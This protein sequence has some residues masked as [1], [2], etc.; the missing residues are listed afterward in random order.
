[1]L[2]V[3]RKRSKPVSAVRFLGAIGTDARPRAVGKIRIPQI[4]DLG[5]K[6][7]ERLGYAFGRRHLAELNTINLCLYN[8]I[9]RR[10]RLEQRLHECEANLHRIID[11]L[12]D[13]IA[14]SR[15]ADAILI[16]V[17]QGFER[18]GY[19]REEALGRSWAQLGVWTAPRQH[20]EFYRRLAADGT[21]LEMEVSLRRRD[22]LKYPAH[23]SGALIELHGETCATTVMRDVSALRRAETSH[24][25]MCEAPL[26][27]LGPGTVPLAHISHEIRTAMNSILGTGELLNETVLDAVQHDYLDIMRRNGEALLGV[28]DGLFDPTGEG[29]ESIED[30]ASVLDLKPVRAAQGPASDAAENASHN[31]HRADAADARATRILLVEDSA[32]NRILVRTYLERI[33]CEIDEAEN[34]EIGVRK[35]AAGSYDIVL[36]DLHMPV[37]D[38][39]DATRM[40]REWEER[41]AARRTW[42]IALTASSY[43]DEV[44]QMI[45]AGADLDVRKPINRA[46][47]IAAVKYLRGRRADESIAVRAAAD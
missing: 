37:M 4:G 9:A 11:T 41:H 5:A 36:M 15:F 19:R 20:E 47:L 16:E 45:E 8:E 23:A 40:I 13:A 39:I 6:V 33:S 12:S 17:N 1:L 35:F 18:L 28:L 22:G 42:V 3:S 46:A 38:G 43:D 44:R 32:D 7:R 30:G 26:T 21:V 10:E 34:G 25:A 24:A 29:A 2:C 27:I 31:G 14:I